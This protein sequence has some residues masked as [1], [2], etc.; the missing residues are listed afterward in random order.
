MVPRNIDHCGLGLHACVPFLE[1]LKTS[2]NFWSFRIFGG[3]R[4]GTFA[5]NRL[6]EIFRNNSSITQSL[7]L[8]L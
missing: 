2:E 4:T 3:Y 8:D 7:D 1:P 6:K 5:L